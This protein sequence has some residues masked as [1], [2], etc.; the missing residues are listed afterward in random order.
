MVETRSPERTISDWFAVREVTGGVWLIAEP[1]HV[2]TW[3]VLGSDR[4]A[5]L[6]TGMGIVPI[7]PLVEQLTDLPICV[8]NTHY[9]YDHTGGNHEFDDIS[10]HES[11]AKALERSWPREVLA[12]YMQY[13]AKLLGSAEAYR[14]LDREFFHLLTPDSEPAPL[15]PGFDPA[16]WDIRPTR[17]NRTLAEGDRV[18]LGDRVLAVLHTP[19]HSP[20]SIC[21]LDERNGLLFGADTVCT[22]PLYAHLAESDLDAYSASAQR[23][24]ELADQLHLVMVHHYGR[25]IV[26]PTFLTEI[27]NGFERLG[28]GSVP[29]T[30]SV[31]CVQ[32][33]VLE[34]RFE[35][36]SILVPDGAPPGREGAGVG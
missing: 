1:G 30:P 9:H 24:A 31:D 23:L 4:A 13:T 25:V 12:A 18:D 21:L 33:P 35:R 26:E 15:P 7:R 34:A 6:D 28:R 17:A 19:G 22:G 14:K 5:L 16:S 36:F 27:A 8:I 29:L 2:N 20:D 3:L 10:I 11:G 32:T